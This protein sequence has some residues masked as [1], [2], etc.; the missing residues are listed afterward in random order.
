MW[1]LTNPAGTTTTA[2]T[3][4][5]ASTRRWSFTSGS[6]QGTLGGPLRLWK[7]R[8][9]PREP[10]RVRSEISREASLSSATYLPPGTT[11]PADALPLAAAMPTGTLCAVNTSRAPSATSGGRVR[12]AASVFAANGSMNPGWLKYGRILSIRGAPGTAPA[13]AT[14]ASMSSRYCRHA[15]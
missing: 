1:S 6:S 14:A 3:P 12:S 7:T 4:S 9:Q 5:F 11:V 13:A 2:G 10:P 15:E 8:S